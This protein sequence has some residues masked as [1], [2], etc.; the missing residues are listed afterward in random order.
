MKLEFTN[1]PENTVTTLESCW[2]IDNAIRW[3]SCDRF[4]MIRFPVNSISCWYYF[5]RK[6]ILGI[7]LTNM[8][9]IQPACSTKATGKHHLTLLPY[10]SWSWEG[11][12]QQA[13]PNIVNNSQSQ[14]RAHHFLFGNLI[15]LLYL[16]SSQI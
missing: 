8:L 4:K 15:L 3:H 9:Q 12:G 5:N 2:A 16:P 11:S 13:I 10:R 7:R 14:T 6:S 1:H